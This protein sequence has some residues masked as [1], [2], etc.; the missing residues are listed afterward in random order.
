[1]ETPTAPLTRLQE[2]LLEEGRRQKWLAERTGIS[3]AQLSAYVRGLHVPDD[4]REAIAEALG[5]T[6]ADVFGTPEI[7]A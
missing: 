5:R 1:M 6:V 3:E 4:R 7:A 2:I